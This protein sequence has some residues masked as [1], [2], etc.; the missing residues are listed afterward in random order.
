MATTIY[1]NSAYR[2][3][4]QQQ[5]VTDA[6]ALDHICSGQDLISSSA[7]SYVWKRR[8]GTIQVYTKKYEYSTRPWRYFLR[9]SRGSNEFA[10]YRYLEQIGVLCPEVVCFAENRHWGRLTWTILMTREVTNATD[11]HTLFTADNLRQAQREAIVVN[12]GEIAARMHS[13]NFFAHDF[14]LRNILYQPGGGD[15]GKNLS[16]RFAPWPQK[17]LLF[18]SSGALGPG[19]ALQT[20]PLSMA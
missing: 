7:H 2:D 3:D 17:Y 18:A 20:C 16:N 5:G 19:N 10:C 9:P 1:F 15:A 13:H 6:V 8:I 4:L 12:V 11:L 14:K